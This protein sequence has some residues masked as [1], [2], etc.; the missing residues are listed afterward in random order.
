MQ[1]FCRD[2]QDK[3]EEDETATNL[4]QLVQSGP[5]VFSGGDVAIRGRYD[6]GTPSKSSDE[7]DDS[8]KTVSASDEEIIQKNGSKKDD[9]KAPDNG[10]D[11]KAYSDRYL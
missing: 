4:Q 8:T 5:L 2:I 10:K 3:K 6:V 7:S 9:T 1:W 11:Y